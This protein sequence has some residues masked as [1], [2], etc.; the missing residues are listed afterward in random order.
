MKLDHLMRWRSLKRKLHHIE[1]RKAPKIKIVPGGVSGWHT[2][3]FQQIAIARLK[4]RLSLRSFVE[5]AN[6]R[7]RHKELDRASCRCE[8]SACLATQEIALKRLTGCLIS[9]RS[10]LRPCWT[11]TIV[12]ASWI[13]D[14]V[15]KLMPSCCK[16][17]KNCFQHWKYRAMVEHAKRS[18]VFAT[19]CSCAREASK[20]RRGSKSFQNLQP[21]LNK[22]WP[23][24]FFSS[25]CGFERGT[26]SWLCS[27]VLLRLPCRTAFGG[28]LVP[29]GL[30]VRVRK[31]AVVLAKHRKRPAQS[32][33]WLERRSQLRLRQRHVTREIQ[34]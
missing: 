16:V 11:I 23:W 3:F 22:T 30:H 27:S 24:G 12:S 9:L 1:T 19:N 2:L 15:A 8:I 14:K 10:S 34:V 29:R 28:I 33:R 6:M 4:G 25:L 31:H 17:T 20:G 21:G 13:V 5:G 26:S 7:L 18:S 32:K